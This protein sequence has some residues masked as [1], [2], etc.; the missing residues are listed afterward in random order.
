MKTLIA[1]LIKS[2]VY[3]ALAVVFTIGF[4]SCQ[5]DDQY[6]KKEK[7]VL[8]VRVYNGLNPLGN[9][10]SE[11]VVSHKDTDKWSSLYLEE[12]DGW[13]LEE[14]FE[15]SVLTWKFWYKEPMMDGPSFVYRFRKVLKKTKAEPL[16]MDDILWN[17]W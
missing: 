10:V 8:T 2:I 6:E 5:K 12:K 11:Y 7:A 17:I 1:S 3:L 13:G 15:Y 9:M 4:S 16:T 14:G